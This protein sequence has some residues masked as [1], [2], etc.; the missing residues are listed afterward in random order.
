[1]VGLI[2]RSGASRGARTIPAEP[3]DRNAL[4][5]SRTGV[6]PKKRRLER[7]RAKRDPVRVKKTRQNKDLESFIV[8]MK[9]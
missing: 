1:M 5:L 2:G 3:A 7:F 9:R 4:C 6:D 8:S